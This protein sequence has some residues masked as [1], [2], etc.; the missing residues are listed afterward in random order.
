MHH[1]IHQ[2]VTEG[3]MSV[4]K[5]TESIAVGIQ[6]VV[7]NMRYRNLRLFNLIFALILQLQLS[8]CKKGGKSTLDPL[9]YNSQ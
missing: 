8:A 4:K 2:P 1:K 9:I 3:P 6:E 5:R 7:I